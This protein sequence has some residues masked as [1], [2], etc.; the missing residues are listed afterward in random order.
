MLVG[1]TST[2]GGRLQ[3]SGRSRAGRPPPGSCRRCRGWWPCRSSGRP[4]PTSDCASPPPRTSEAPTVFGFAGWG[5][6][7]QMSFHVKVA[8]RVSERFR[9]FCRRAPLQQFPA[10][11]GLHHSH[12]VSREMF[13][14][15]GGRTK[16]VQNKKCPQNKNAPKPRPPG[17]AASPPLS[18]QRYPNRTQSSG[19]PFCPTFIREQPP[20]TEK[21]HAN[22]SSVNHDRVQSH[23]KRPLFLPGC[24]AQTGE[25]IRR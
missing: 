6:T 21:I 19:S 24:S 14:S 10:T 22:A 15:S 25:A 8:T 4:S 20:L 3:G 1:L 7:T 13:H 9:G 18:P 2:G 5:E 11:W 17:R 23:K 12:R 16:K